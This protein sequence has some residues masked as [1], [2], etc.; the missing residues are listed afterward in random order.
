MRRLGA[1]VMAAVLLW[2]V[3][4][5]AEP[6]AFA[7]V[8]Q[9]AEADWLD[10]EAK[11][12]Y[13]ALGTRSLTPDG[14]LTVGYVGRGRCEV[15]K[16]K[17]FTMVSCFGRGEGRELS[18][19][20]FQIDPALSSAEMTFESDGYKHHVTWTGEE[21]PVAGTQGS[22][23][24]FGLQ[25]GAG[26]ARFAPASGTLYGQKV[27]ASRDSFGVLSE[28]GFAVA[29]NDGRRVTMLDDGSVRVSVSYKI[30]R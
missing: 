9:M 7:G 17:S 4:A 10:L 23:S 3:A 24:S 22:A 6:G 14:L 19:E 18:M 2:P 11:R 12:F 5:V 30:P 26:V 28:S 21:V 29:Y 13:F 1:V 25:A 27:K 20:E 8:D 16:T 15:Q